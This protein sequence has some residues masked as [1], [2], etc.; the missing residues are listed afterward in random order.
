[1][2]QLNFSYDRRCGP[3]LCHLAAIDNSSLAFRDIEGSIPSSGYPA[4]LED[5]LYLGKS[6]SNR[7]DLGHT[8]GCNVFFPFCGAALLFAT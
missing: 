8:R 1:M 5:H 4:E 7:V 3:L 6:F 2:D